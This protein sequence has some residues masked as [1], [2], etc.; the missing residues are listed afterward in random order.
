MKHFAGLIHLRQ[1]SFWANT[2]EDAGPGLVQPM[3]ELEIL[4]LGFA[5]V[6]DCRA[7]IPGGTDS[8]A[9]IKYQG[10]GRNRCGAAAF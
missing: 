8:S 4:E 1:V 10:F 7:Q 2:I 6:T 5:P 9:I 3:T